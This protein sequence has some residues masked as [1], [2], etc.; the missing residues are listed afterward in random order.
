MNKFITLFKDSAKELKKTRCITLAA[1]L[2][3]TAIVLSQFT[4]VVSDFLK[5]GFAFLPNRI[6]YYLF[7]P[8]VGIIYGAAMD[9][10]TYIVKPTGPFH[11]GFT[12][13]AA[14]TGLIFGLIL[15]KRPLKLSRIF[16]AS[17]IKMIIVNIILNSYWISSIT[18]KAFIAIMPVRITKNILLLPVE[19]LLLF[20]VIKALELTGAF[21]LLSLNKKKNYH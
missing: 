8:F 12:I 14:I 20:S 16:I 3:A 5:I 19:A 4:I 6:V 10:L 17:T 15:Y 11:P 13:N 7:G 9:I 21:K 2:G 1:M 18:G